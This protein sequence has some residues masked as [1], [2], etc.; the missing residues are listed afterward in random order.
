L[1]KE[2]EVAKSKQE[3]G[4]KGVEEEEALFSKPL[5]I[6]FIRNPFTGPPPHP[7]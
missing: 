1:G 5:A 7:P 6:H 2:E 4:L 3:E